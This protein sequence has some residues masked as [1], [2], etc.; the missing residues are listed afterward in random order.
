MR[1]V[2]QEAAI[3]RAVEE[4]GKLTG[5]KQHETYAAGNEATYAQNRAAEYPSIADQLDMQYHDGVNGTTTWAVAIAAVKT[6]YPKS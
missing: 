6:K 5:W 2:G 1:I 3:A 4:L